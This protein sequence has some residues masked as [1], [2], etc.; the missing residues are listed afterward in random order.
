[1]N[2]NQLFGGTYR[3]HFQDHKVNQATN[4]HDTGVNS[5]KMELKCSSENSV[6]F[7]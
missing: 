4:K 7:E 1:M 5:M 2:V 3:R 6:D